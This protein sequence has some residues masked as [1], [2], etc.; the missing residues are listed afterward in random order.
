DAGEFFNDACAG[1]GVEAL[2]VA[3]FA[4]FDAGV[5]VHQDEAAVRGD[6]RA[7]VLADIVVGGNR[8]ANADAAV[9]GDLCRDIADALDV[10][11]PVLFRKAQLT[12]EIFAHDVAIQERD[13]T[14]ADFQ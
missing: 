10:D 14:A 2:A 5:D 8:R 12:G 1:F 7:D 6:H 11:V 3:F 13:R 9:L 4:F